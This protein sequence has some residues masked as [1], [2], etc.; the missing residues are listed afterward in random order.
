MKIPRTGTREMPEETVSGEI[1]I[2][3]LNTANGISWALWHVACG[4]GLE[5]DYTITNLRM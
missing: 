5:A 2:D 1:G 4:L 3:R